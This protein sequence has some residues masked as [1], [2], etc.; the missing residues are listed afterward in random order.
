MYNHGIR[1]LRWLDHVQL[2]IDF[3]VHS[4]IPCHTAGRLHKQ[5]FQC[6]NQNAHFKC[7]F[8]TV[9]LRA[10]ETTAR[11]VYTAGRSFNLTTPF[12]SL[13]HRLVNYLLTV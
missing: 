13:G 6:P 7:P 8:D 3:T 10:R 1:N 2:N 5:S 9:V 4:C 12:I 11:G